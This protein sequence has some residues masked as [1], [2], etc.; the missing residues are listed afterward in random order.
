[1]RD[2][3]SYRCEAAVTAWRYGVLES[4]H[5][6]RDSLWRKVLVQLPLRIVA[7]YTS[8][9][10]S[11][12]ALYR[13]PDTATT[14]VDFDKYVRGEGKSIKNQLVPLGADPNVFKGVQLSRL[15]GCRREEKGTMQRLLYFNPTATATP[16]ERN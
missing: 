1:M 4:D 10:R 11:T 13:L 9:G 6:E 15:P 12:H 7:I 14:K 2:R 3:V 16:I 5:G 8:G